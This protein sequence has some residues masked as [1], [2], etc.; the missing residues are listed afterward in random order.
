M[1]EG[2]NIDRVT[3]PH[4]AL[5]KMSDSAQALAESINSPTIATIECAGHNALWIDTLMGNLKALGT[6]SVEP[7]ALREAQ[8][9]SRPA[10]PRGERNKSPS[11]TMATIPGTGFHVIH[12]AVLVRFGPELNRKEYV[13]NPLELAERVAFLRISVLRWQEEL[14]V[15]F[16][17]ALNSLTSTGKIRMFI[18][19]SEALHE[20]RI[21]QLAS[22]VSPHVRL[23]CIAGPSSS[24]KT[25]FSNRLAVHLKVN[26]QSCRRISLDDF[27]RPIGDVPLDEHGAKDFEHL[28]S[29]RVEA[30][31]E[32]LDDLCN[33]RSTV[34]PHYDFVTGSF[35]DGPTISLEADTTVIIE[36][37]HALNPALT[38][39]LDQSSVLR[40]FIRP[41]GD[42]LRPV[43][44]SYGPTSE[45]E[46]TSTWIFPFMDSADCI[47]N[48][49]TMHEL[50]VLRTFAFPL[51]KAMK[52]N[53]IHFP[54]ARRL[55]RLLEPIMPV[56]ES[57]VPDHSLLREFLPGGSKF[58]KE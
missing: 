14:G 47:F 22:K 58:N 43:P 9:V 42:A 20:K 36:G 44:L 21:A 49:S 2:H 57:Y 52:P 17:G 19:V 12:P 27:Y 15:P 30:I 28:Q 50:C 25:T 26:G 24:G 8:V 48:S 16:L 29:L 11:R 32:C 37:I 35:S 51:L 55:I 38:E 40:I 3:L 5:A 1:E 10:S 18:E 45:G 13:P 4:S 6:V 46:R 7:L 39:H 23:V 56:P 41:L 54:V 34:I 53:D 33:G 31:K